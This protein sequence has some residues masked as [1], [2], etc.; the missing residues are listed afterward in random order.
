VIEISSRAEGIF[1]SCELLV[2]MLHFYGAVTE[3]RGVEVT[4]PSVPEQGKMLFAGLGAYPHLDIAP[5]MLDRVASV[6]GSKR[7]IAMQCGFSPAEAER[8]VPTA[9]VRAA[10]SLAVTCSFHSIAVDFDG[11]LVP[12]YSGDDVPPKDVCDQ[13]EGL[14]E[15]GINVGIFTGRGRSVIKGLRRGLRSYLWGGVTAFLYNGGVRWNLDDEFP[16]WTLE[17]ANIAEVQAIVANLPLI[18]SE[19][20]TGTEVASLGSQVTINVDPSAPAAF[21][22][23]LVNRIGLKVAELG[24]A[25]ASSGRSVDIFPV[26]ASKELALRRWLG[27]RGFYRWDY[28]VLRIG[29]R[30]DGIGN[31]HE[32]LSSCCGF[33]VDKYSWTPRGCFPASSVV[34][35]SSTGPVLTAELLQCLVAEE[36]TGRL[37]FDLTKAL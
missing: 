7:A 18:L 10:L 11:T 33:S 25:V 31:D 15:C 34:L 12:L 35:S 27:E 32:F 9:V 17:I 29:D 1:A 22:E 36:R 23:E 16:S 14:L 21:Q 28:G 5:H 4:S 24:L 6:V 20:C 3:H 8:Q 19:W 2:W 13:L 30:G 26:T 37:H